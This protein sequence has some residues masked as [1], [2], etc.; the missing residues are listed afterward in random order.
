MRNLTKGPE[1]V[2]GVTTINARLFQKINDDISHIGRRNDSDKRSIT[3][4]LS[5][6]H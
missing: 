1:S 5:M 4:Y 3:S 6:P 2:L